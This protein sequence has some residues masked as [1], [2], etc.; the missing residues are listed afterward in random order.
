MSER[1]AR[2]AS[3]SAPQQAYAIGPDSIT[4]REP[5]AA[6]TLS[7]W[8]PGRQAGQRSRI[9]RRSGNGSATAEAIVEGGREGRAV[10][11]PPGASCRSD[12]SR[13][14][15]PPRPVGAAGDPVTARRLRAVSGVALA[16][17]LRMTADGA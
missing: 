13:H 4:V 12:C 10:Q 14:T 17:R 11:D 1:L 5:A 2:G 3:R 8:S 15:N 16:A 9:R 6:L 7:R